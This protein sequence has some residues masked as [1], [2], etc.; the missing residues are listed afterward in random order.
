LVV[1]N[2]WSVR[3]TY[4]VGEATGRVSITPEI[5]RISTDDGEHQSVDVEIPSMKGIAVRGSDLRRTVGIK[6]VIVGETRCA[7]GGSACEILG[8]RR[9]LVHTN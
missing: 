7:A 6:E 2:V 3:D 5:D 1:E 4:A 8:D 9:H